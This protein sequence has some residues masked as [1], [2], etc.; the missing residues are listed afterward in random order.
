MI[1]KDEE[2]FLP[3]CLDS[4]CGIVDEIIIVDT[5]SRDRT[6]EIAQ[7]YTSKIYDFSWCDDFSAA[8]NYS[9]EQA[10]QEYIMWLDADDILLPED[11][12]KL[13]K[14]KESLSPK[15]EVVMMDYCLSFD[16]AGIPLVLSRRHRLVRRD[17]KLKW[18][19]IVHEYIDVAGAEVCFA[20]VAVA[21]RR[22]GSHAER[23]LR[24][25]EQW[26]ASG[27]RLEGRLLLHYGSELADIS[28]L[29]E[30]AVQLNRFLL[31]PGN[32]LS[33]CV[34]A[35]IKLADCCEKLGL[36]EKKL[37]TLLRSFQY[38]TPQ[39]EVCCA[40]GGCFEERG[41]W[42]TAIYWYRQA[43]QT[44]EEL[45]L[46]FMENRSF[47][48]WLPHCRLCIC[49]AKLGNLEKADWHNEQALRYLPQDPQ[50]LANRSKF[51]NLLRPE[52]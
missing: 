49:Y 31:Q 6:K 13:K 23:N 26:I 52:A 16:S 38:D 39:S 32:A 8:R 2:K 50:L 44:A 47:R 3:E 10:T 37:E 46:G 15:R 45:V 7:K 22:Q 12:E 41:Q 42:E 19:G 1:V 17:K 4:V 28:R 27:G 14:L 36:K 25:I 18:V 20:N 34:L 9:F 35:C 48:T 29:E 11:Q 24:I 30:A 21:H 43:L 33:D 40:I 51:N 5:G